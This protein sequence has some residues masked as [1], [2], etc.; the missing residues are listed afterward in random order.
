MAWEQKLM[1]TVRVRNSQARGVLAN[2]LTA[3]SESGGNVGG[4]EML[5]ETSHNVVRDITV[6]AEDEAHVEQIVAAMRANEGTKILQVRDEVL[7]LH[8]KGKIAIRSRYPDRFPGHPATRLH[9]RRGR[10]SAA[11]SPRTHP[12]RGRTPASATWSPS[13]PTGRRCSASATSVRWR[14]C[15]SWKARPC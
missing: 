15:R 12:W 2:L 7:E 13:S 8:Q 11:R 6:Y 5:T 3:I 14:A 4:I 10:R 1:R 9:A